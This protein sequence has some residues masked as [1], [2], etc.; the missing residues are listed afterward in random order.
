MKS[1]S[2]TVI[3]TINYDIIVPQKGIRYESLGGILYNVIS[4]SV[5]SNNTYRIIP[6]T[7]IGLQT[8]ERL[9]TILSEHPCV[10]QEG[11]KE[12]EEEINCNILKY[13]NDNER[14]ET[15]TF[16][17]GEIPYEMI[18]PYLHTDCLLFNFIS[19]Y[20]VSLDT[21][22]LVRE[23]THGLIFF[24]VHSLVLEKSVNERP[25][26]K[27][28]NWKEWIHYTDIVQM[29]T[30]ELSYFTC[31]QKIPVL[32]TAGEYGVYLGFDKHVSFFPQK[33]TS[34]VK[35]TTG[36]GDIFSA[37]F[38]VRYLTTKDPY[39][40]CEFANLTAGF[41]T[42]ESGLNKCDVLRQLSSPHF[43]TIT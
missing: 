20:D 5:L 43:H 11:I 39:L 19:G 4:L 31:N 22:K 17:T 14:I 28:S 9:K 42:I 2:I 12:I 23:N 8:K 15:T 26:R 16:R 7:Y 6:V 38:L 29:N 36:C 13:L 25:F 10:L 27:I 24:D 21:M 37:S 34:T 40:A 33:F 18:E 32:I 1:P 30:T 35:D 3:G 41:V